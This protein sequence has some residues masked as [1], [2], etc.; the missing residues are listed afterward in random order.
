[1]ENV[2]F[3]GL[4][5][6]ADSIAI[7]VAEPGRGEPALL[8]TIAHDVPTLLRRLRRLGTVKCCY[9]AGPTGFGLH[10]ALTGAGIDC[11]VVAPSLVP[12]RA[13]DRV[14]TDR[15]DAV[16]LARF[17]RSGD[18]TA[19][20]V[21]SAST[22]AMRDL[23][24]ARDD[25]RK[26]ERVARHQLAK[27]LLRQGR[28]YDGK[29]TWTKQHGRWLATQGFELPAQQRVF[30]DYLKTVQ[31]LSERVA[32]LTKSVAELVESWE[33]KPL[34]YALQALRGIKLVSAVVLAAEVEN[35][36]RFGRA[37]K[38]MAYTGLVP[39]EHSSGEGRR[40]GRITRTGNRHV[41]RILVEAAWAYRYRPALSA[42]LRKRSRGVADG[43]QRIAWRAQTRL[44]GRYIQLLARGKNAN[45][46]ITAVARE[47]AGFVWA[48][49]REEKLLEAV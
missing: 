35:F 23:E 26:A 47:L 45:K 32:R 21:P 44:C 15:R 16:K 36:A 41:R 31:D 49:S 8:A 29:T 17:L 38:F 46:A 25:A 1:M 18:L 27:F 12:M 37:S 2:R 33:L 19:V 22:E 10:R 4:D 20:H 5:V 14:K 11:M 7:A 9:E 6:H 43:V 28:R 48:V 34:V 40:Q 3:V 24:R 30:E 13:G 39:S 42:P